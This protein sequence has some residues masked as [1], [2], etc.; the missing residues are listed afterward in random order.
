MRYRF[1]SAGAL[2]TAVAA[3]LLAVA[4]PA[5]ASATTGP[6]SSTTLALTGF[7]SIVADSGH[8]QVFVSGYGSDPVVVTDFAGKPV[9]TLPALA[10]ATSLALSQGGTILY[11]A[12]GGTDE[13]AAV[14]TDTLQEV[15]LY[16]T[17]TGHNPQHLA[18]VGHDV[19]FS[20]GQDAD[21]GLGELDPVTLSVTTTHEADFYYPAV[22]A[23]APSAPN[24]LVAGNPHIS[25]SVIESFN[26][27]TGTPVEIAKSDPWAQSDGCENLEQLAVTASGADAVAACGAPYH[28]SQLSLSGMQE[29]ATYQ[30]G[31]YPDSVAVSQGSGTIA[32]G[33]DGTSTVVDLFSPGGTNPTTTC[34]LGGSGVYGL[35]WD[36]S[37]S[38]LFAVTAGVN[39]ATVPTLNVIDVP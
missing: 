24:T 37:G 3:G 11:A 17:G 23:A 28:G 29:D 20:Y 2:T 15:A 12:I 25:P 31:P 27:A 10:G 1:Q 21:T 8:H 6:T 33:A 22:L 5:P 13:I 32:V 19:W 18:V 16:F 34:Q 14:R 39:T 4:A 35:A 30:T 7:T 36:A 9:T 38:V 26:V